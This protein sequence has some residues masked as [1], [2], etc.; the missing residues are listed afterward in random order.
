[1]YVY[2]S[3]GAY[4][5]DVYS[6]DG[7]EFTAGATPASTNLVLG[8]ANYGRAATGTEFSF[9]VQTNGLYPMQ[10]IYFKAQ[11]GGGGV[12]LYSIS[13]TGSQA[14]LNDPQAVGA[15][16]VYYLVPLPTLSVSRSGNQL[17]MTWTNPNYSL[18]SAPAVTG[19]YSTISSSASPYRYNITGT[20]E[21]FRLIKTQ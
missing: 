19:P 2:L 13:Q 18:Q 15:L 11:L 16:P 10:L 6:D 7:F 20:Q 5:F 8:I 21:Y 14:L 1:M 9:I 3:P 17:V 4:N 12:E